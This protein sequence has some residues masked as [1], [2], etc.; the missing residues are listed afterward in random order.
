MNS[1]YVI[2]KCTEAE[3]RRVLEAESWTLSLEEL[4]AFGALIYACGL[5]GTKGIK[6]DDLW[7]SQWGV[8]FFLATVGRIRF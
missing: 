6:V 1:C 7:S 8:V 2:Q 3:A 5:Y 4:N